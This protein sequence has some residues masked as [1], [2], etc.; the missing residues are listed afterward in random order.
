[1][2]GTAVQIMAFYKV[3]EMGLVHK[4]LELAFV[5]GCVGFYVIDLLFIETFLRVTTGGGAA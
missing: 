4:R 5:I 2:T 1:M 3:F